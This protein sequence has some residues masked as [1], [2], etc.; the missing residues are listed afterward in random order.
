MAEGYPGLSTMDL[1]QVPSQKP[2]PGVN[3]NFVNPPTRA[4]IT[5]AIVTVT[6][7]LMIVFVLLRLYADIGINRKLE[8]AGSINFAQCLAYI[9]GNAIVCVPAPGH[10]WQ[11]AAARHSCLVTANLLGVILAAISVFNDFFIIVIPI[12]LIWALQMSTKKKA[13]I[14]AIFFTGLLVC[15]SSI[16]NLVFRLRQ[17]RNRYHDNTWNGAISYMLTLV[18][19][20]LDSVSSRLLYYTVNPFKVYDMKADMLRVRAVEINVAIMCSCMPCYAAFV[21]RHKPFLRSLRSR[22]RAHQGYWGFSSFRKLR[23]SKRSTDR[24]SDV[25]KIDLRQ[26]KAETPVYDGGNSPLTLGSAVRDGRFLKTAD[27]SQ[28]VKS[29]PLQSDHSD[30]GSLGET[31]R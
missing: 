12:P 11:L 4:P 31:L 5:K 29:E 22:L 27:R 18:F 30:D 21:R 25:E 6:L 20:F 15:I 26:L 10:S 17:Y 16:L 19:L 8:K 28:A 3:P 9:V 24:D 23:D 13:G 14:S 2:P 1:S 7:V